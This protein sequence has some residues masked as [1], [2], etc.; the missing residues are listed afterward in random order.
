MQLFWT[1]EAIQD[2][3]EIYTLWISRCIA[4]AR[5]RIPGSIANYITGVSECSQQRGNLKDDGYKQQSFI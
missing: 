1:P 5:E 2:R 4:T 3:E